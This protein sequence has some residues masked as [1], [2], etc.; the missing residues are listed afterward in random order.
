ML[1]GNINVAVKKNI[2]IKFEVL[3]HRTLQSI[4]IVISKINHYSLQVTKMKI[5]KIIKAEGIVNTLVQ[6]F[7][8]IVSRILYFFLSRTKMWDELVDDETKEDSNAEED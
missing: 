3:D 5:I 8:L 6:G 7:Y 2:A 4:Q 1:G